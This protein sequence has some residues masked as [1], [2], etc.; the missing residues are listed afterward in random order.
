MSRNPLGLAFRRLFCV[1]GI[2]MVG[3]VGSA[4]AETKDI[5][6][7]APPVNWEAI[8]R[9]M[10]YADQD[11]NFVNLAG[12]R[13]ISTTVVLDFYTEGLVDYN[14]FFLQMAVPTI[15]DVPF[16]NLITVHGDALTEVGPG[17]YAIKF[18]TEGF[19]GL[20]LDSRFGIAVHGYL[21][22]E[23]F[24]IPGHMGDKSGISFTIDMDGFG[25]APVPE[26]EQAWL[27]LA[28]LAVLPWMR[29]RA[30]ATSTTGA[31]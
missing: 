8:Y 21:N 12:Q 18:T 6:Y 11:D 14:Q 30:A 17:H 2:L 26:P 10:G 4:R 20:I 5:F 22:G 3:M 31:Q 19:N 24:S 28:G 16:G 1:F 29:R 23:S 15:P 7:S 27:L 25:A 13:I 9:G